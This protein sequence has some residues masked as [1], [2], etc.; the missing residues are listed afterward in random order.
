MKS[1]QNRTL[2]IAFFTM[3]VLSL[4]LFSPSVSWAE[5]DLIPMGRE[6]YDRFCTQ[7]HGE[8]G[9]GDG[10]NTEFLDPAPRDLTDSQEIYMAKLTNEEV[11]EVIN[12]GGAGIDKSPKMPPFGMTLSEHEIVAL[13]IYVRTLHPNNAG[14]I[15]HSKLNK[16]RPRTE[17]REIEIGAPKGK[18]A[19]K[20]AKR[21]YKKYSCS[22]CH[23]VNGSGG[24]S[25]PALDGISSR[26]KPQ[27]IFKVVKDPLT[28][29]E[30]SSMPNFGLNDEVAVYITQYLLSL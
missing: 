26:M 21:Y 19:L 10:E 29:K 28:V 17:W 1:S 5:E 24:T 8:E 11:I 18:R 22:G 13:S 23:R 27:E 16:E 4:L 30:D 15:D 9:K 12:K 25:G 6:I 2:T 14:P 20:I 3:S 7:C